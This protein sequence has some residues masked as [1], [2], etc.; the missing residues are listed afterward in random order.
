[1][2]NN[3]KQ[4][5][6]TAVDTARYEDDRLHVRLCGQYSTVF[7][8]YLPPTLGPNTPKGSRWSRNFLGGSRER[9]A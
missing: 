5:N 7:L 2:T 4:F 6:C 3:M 9:R 1:M 8:L